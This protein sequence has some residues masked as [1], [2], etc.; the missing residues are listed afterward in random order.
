[1]ANLDAFIRRI[2]DL[3]EL[4][5]RESSEAVR[6]VALTLDQLLVLST[7]VDTGR[8]RSN[9]LVGINAPRRQEVDAL[10]KSGQQPIQVAAGTIAEAKPGDDVWL[11]NN[12]PYIIRLNDGSSPQASAGFVERAVEQSVDV[13]RGGFTLGRRR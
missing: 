13:I 1:M 3:G 4:V 8:A 10:D 12:L 7:P 6:T 2:D 9:W 11:S 5:F